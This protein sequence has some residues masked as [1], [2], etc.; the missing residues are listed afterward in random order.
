MLSVAERR[1]LDELA[2]RLGHAVPD[3]VG[4]YLTG[5]GAYGDHDP[6]RSDVDIQAVVAT[7]PGRDELAAAVAAVRHDAL[8]CP[9]R[10]LELV[11]YPAGVVTRP[12]PPLA[13]ALNLNTGAAMEDRMTTDPAS[14]PAHWF[15]LDVAVS[16]AKARALLG[17]PPSTVFGSVSPRVI[18]GALA[19]SLEWHLDQEARTPNTVLNAC[20]SWY[21]AETGDW[22]S[23]GQAADWVLRLRP[24][25]SVVAEALERRSSGRL[26]EREPV[27]SLSALAA[28]AL[29]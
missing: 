2:Q 20:R 18:R 6:W 5:S 11:V 21:F 3:L 1:Y 17:P 22:A 24:D 13:F 25:L 9:A 19:E 10:A 12:Y 15:L 8:A 29:G 28:A 16:R 27:R 26:L 14:E 23:K 4:V 7:V